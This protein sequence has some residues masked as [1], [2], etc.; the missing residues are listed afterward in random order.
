MENSE[1]KLCT[2]E[3]CGSR[4]SEWID[5]CGEPETEWC[6][7]CTSRFDE[8]YLDGQLSDRDRE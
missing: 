2:C 1:K 4:F 7:I 6:R 3:E 8:S 5:E